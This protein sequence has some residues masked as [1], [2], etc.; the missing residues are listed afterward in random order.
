MRGVL[1][2]LAL[3]L[4]IGACEGSGADGLSPMETSFASDTPSDTG[5]NQ[6]TGSDTESN[7]VTQAESESQSA[8]SSEEIE[9][10]SAEIYGLIDVA[11]RSDFVA[12]AE[13]IDD[14]E[15]QDEHLLQLTSLVPAFTGT[16]GDLVIPAAE[17]TDYEILV[18]RLQTDEGGVFRIV[19]FAYQGMKLV[20]PVIE[21]R[22]PTDAYETGVD[23]GV[24]IGQGVIF[25]AYDLSASF[26]KQCVHAISGDATMTVDLAQ[27]LK[28]LDGGKLHLSG[29]SIPLYYIAKTPH[30][31]L[32]SAMDAPACEKRP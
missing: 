9:D 5:E 31:D 28:S 18:L 25:T 10:T 15:Y 27:S 17:V 30:G 8:T 1:L 20:N 26:Q 22:L 3:G 11:L 23:I 6:G 14:V 13:R 19:Q 7:S 2:G 29:A 32:S 21:L 24:C 4:W 12:D 16:V